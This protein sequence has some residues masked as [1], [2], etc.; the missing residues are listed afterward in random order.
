[1][2]EPTG[3]IIVDIGGG[4]SEVAVISLGGIVTSRSIRVAGDEIDDAIVSLR[5]QVL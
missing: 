3:S 4:T 1:M 5:A 2:S